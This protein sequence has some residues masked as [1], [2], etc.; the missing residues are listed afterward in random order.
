MLARDLLAELAA[1]GLPAVAATRRDLDI[2]D[3][4]AVRAAFAAHRP[5]VVVNCAA[6]TAVDAAEEHE[7]EAYAINATGPRLLSA[8]CRESGALLLHLSTDYVFD[9]QAR[10]PYAEDAP[11]APR[12][13][14]G[15]TKLAGEQAVR[16]LLPHTG[17]IIRTAWLYGAGGTSFIR[18]AINLERTR[19]TVDVVTDQLGQPTWTADLA[20][21]LVELG[22]RALVGAAPPGTYHGTSTG[23]TTWFTLCQEV[24][25]LLGADPAR[26]RP[27]TSDRY[28]R[29]APRPAYSALAHDRW[30]AAGLP[31][32]RH[33]R[34]ALTEAFPTLLPPPE[35]PPTPATTPARNP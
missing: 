5:A 30:Q 17:Y 28:V 14:Y 26:V 6:W 9:G 20:H 12:S 7:P 19:P 13:A 10:T 2:T 18:T 22:V 32:L 11:T 21:R 33:W 3:P 34:T 31:P 24:F 29:P 23:T 4:A 27:T 1:A 15:R 8:A 35:P 25:R 16:T